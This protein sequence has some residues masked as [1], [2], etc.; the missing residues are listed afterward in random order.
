MKK[1]VITMFNNCMLFGHT[2]LDFYQLNFRDI[3]IQVFYLIL[4]VN[5]PD[6]MQR[7][8]D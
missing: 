8:F 4:N 3:F 5:Q 1:N 2:K 7:R 6:S